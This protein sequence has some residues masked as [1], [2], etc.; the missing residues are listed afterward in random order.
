MASEGSFITVYDNFEYTESVKEQRWEENRTLK[1]VTSGKIMEG[2]KMPEG[3]LQQSMVDHSV[4]LSPS[5]I[6]NSAG[7]QQDTVEKQVWNS[8][9]LRCQKNP[10]LPEPPGQILWPFLL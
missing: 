10:S 6:T 2:R 9:S 1:S 5:D 7:N 4:A 3:G 8:H